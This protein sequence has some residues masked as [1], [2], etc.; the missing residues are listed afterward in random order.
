MSMTYAK[1]FK[2]L[3]KSSSKLV[4]PNQKNGVF[5]NFWS[6]GYSVIDKKID[7]SG[8]EII[9]KRFVPTTIFEAALTI[10]NKNMV[11]KIS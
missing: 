4:N 3:S 8:K 9:K 6:P 11:R 2:T 1:G 5:L 10:L 7:P